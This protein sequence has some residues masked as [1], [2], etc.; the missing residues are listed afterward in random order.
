MLL[1]DHVSS[2]SDSSLTAL[3]V[4]PVFLKGNQAAKRGSALA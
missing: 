2:L 1:V 4:L 3:S